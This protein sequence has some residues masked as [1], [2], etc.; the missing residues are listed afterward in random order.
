M[1]QT[2]WPGRRNGGKNRGG[3]HRLPGAAPC[4]LPEEEEAA[5]GGEHTVH[6]VPGPP[7][8]SM[9]HI[10][11]SVACLSCQAGSVVRCARFSLSY[12]VVY[13]FKKVTSPPLYCFRNEKKT[14]CIAYNNQYRFVNIIAGSGFRATGIFLTSWYFFCLL[15]P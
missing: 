14:H 8:S 5:E 1:S 9:E 6:T 4:V 3:T 15:K 11:V 13:L 7:T 10:Y 12:V 2:S